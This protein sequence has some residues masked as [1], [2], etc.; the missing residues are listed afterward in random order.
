MS[1]LKI[2]TAILA[3]SICIFSFASC[4]T[5]IKN[6][7]GSNSTQTATAKSVT[8]KQGNGKNP[9]AT[10]TAK[11]E[12]QSSNK[13]TKKFT[14]INIHEEDP[15][16]MDSQTGETV[17]EPGETLPPNLETGFGEAF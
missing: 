11:E 8:V 3:L 16:V 6:K 14:G 1:R 12:Y 9:S 4:G 10:T 2:V 15:Y 5:N 17:T 13:T 7:N